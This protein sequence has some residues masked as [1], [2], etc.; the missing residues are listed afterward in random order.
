MA[1]G[2]EEL[3]TFLY[4]QNENDNVDLDRAREE[5]NSLQN[6]VI[7]SATPIESDHH[8]HF[9]PSR[10]SNHLKSTVLF[11]FP[12]PDQHAAHHVNK[13]P[14]PD[15]DEREIT[16]YAAKKFIA[17]FPVP[18]EMSRSIASMYVLLSIGLFFFFSLSLPLF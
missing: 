4:Q 7:A 9:S 12:A 5:V 1:V 14:S 13:K 10:Y 17:Q 16:E 2:D 11:P 3:Q 15:G 6:Q 18:Q 8:H